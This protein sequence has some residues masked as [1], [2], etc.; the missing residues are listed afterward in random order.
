MAVAVLA[1]S[2]SQGVEVS[3]SEA[4]SMKGGCKGVS[5]SNCNAAGCPSDPVYQ[6]GDLNLDGINVRFCTGSYDCGACYGSATSCRS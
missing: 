4:S 2:Q 1:S 3:N 6:G 5:F